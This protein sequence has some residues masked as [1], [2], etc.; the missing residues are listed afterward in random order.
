MKIKKKRLYCKL[1]SPTL[2]CDLNKI[3][4]VDTAAAIFPF[5]SMHTAPTVS[6]TPST[7]IR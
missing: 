2:P 1:T 6:E 7:Y 3:P 4:P 5:V